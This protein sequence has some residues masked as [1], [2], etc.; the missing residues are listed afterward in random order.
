CLKVLCKDYGIDICDASKM[1]S[2]APAKLHKIDKDYGSI[3]VGKI[4]DLVI[5]D[6]NYTVKNVILNGVIQKL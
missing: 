1:L 6:C 5:T 2:L 3:E 4:A